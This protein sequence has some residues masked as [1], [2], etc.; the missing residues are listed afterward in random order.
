MRLKGNAYKTNCRLYMKDGSKPGCLVENHANRAHHLEDMAI[1][2][3]NICY[4][5]TS[6]VTGCE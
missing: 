2:R 1:E 6:H 5:G 3:F 4:L